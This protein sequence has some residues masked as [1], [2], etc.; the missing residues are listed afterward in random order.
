MIELDA[1]GAAARERWKRG[2]LDVLDFTLTSSVAVDESVVVSCPAMG[3][4]FIGFH[5]RRAPFDDARVRRAFAHA[6]DRHRFA[7]AFGGTA[8]PTGG[9]IPPSMPG[10]SHA[11]APAFDPDRA[12]A[13]LR[14]AGYPDGRALGEV[15]LAGLDLGNFTASQIA[16]QLDA[17]G[18]DVRL[19]PTSSDLEQSVAVRDHAHVYMHG[20][21]ADFPDP[22]GGFLESL[23]RNV[24]LYREERLEKLLADAASLH[25]RDDRLRVYREF[26]RIWI[27]EQVAVVPLTYDD[28]AFWCRPWVTGMWV[29]PIVGATFAEAV[30]HRT[31]ARGD[32]IGS[33]P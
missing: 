26:E 25:D 6:I 7:R 32:A 5:Y 31:A 18:I 8:A 21:A 4:S 24:P 1:T 14:E 22:G 20:W 11:V 33:E 19:L 27:G 10:H 16:A 2:E 13:L 3:T 17:I 30:V 29:N 23:L 12:R 28:V 15:V 9:L